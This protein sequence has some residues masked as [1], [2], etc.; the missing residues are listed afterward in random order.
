MKP[1][2]QLYR[3]ALKSLASLLAR[4]LLFPSSY[5]YH[6]LLGRFLGALNRNQAA[7]SIAL[8]ASN[9]SDQFSSGTVYQYKEV[10]KWGG[11]DLK[12][13]LDL[14]KERI[15]DI[16]IKDEVLQYLQVAGVESLLEIGCEAGQNLAVIRE[17]M[18]EMKLAGCDISTKALSIAERAGVAVRTVNLLEIDALSVYEDDQ[19]D[20]VLISHVLEHLVVRD[21]QHTNDIRCNVLKHIHRIA[22]RGYVVTTTAIAQTPVPIMLLFLGHARVALNAF[23]VADLDKLGVS[24][25]F[26]T[27][28]RLDESLSLIVRK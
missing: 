23:S 17:A 10:V 14:A 7:R 26:V 15:F 16:F 8:F 27:S 9:S 2:N 18:P 21:I 5:R 19:F 22:K 1:P 12:V 24:S 4:S 11:F 3:V 28:N 20:Y 25:F 6:T 13:N